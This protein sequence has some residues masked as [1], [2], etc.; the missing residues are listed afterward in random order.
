VRKSRLF[1]FAAVVRSLNR[2]NIHKTALLVEAGLFLIAS[3]LLLSLVPFRLLSN[4][5][6]DAM[7]E[8]S[9]MVSH[10]DELL[11]T[12]VAWALKAFGLRLVWSRKCLLQAMAASWMLRRR[13][14]NS[15]LYLGVCKDDANTLA[16]H[17]W[18]RAGGN[19]VV[20]AETQ[21]DFRVVG[22]FGT[23]S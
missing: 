19:I 21:L 10:P 2:L 20:G 9:Q 8:S 18:V 14:L 23:R 13:G 17:A 4:L 1:W 22:M 6:G 5:L 16:A 12:E 15:T 11:L 7:A 3:K